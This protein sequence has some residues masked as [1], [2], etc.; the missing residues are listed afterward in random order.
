MKVSCSLVS[1][2]TSPWTVAY[3]APLS[4]GFSRQGYRSG[5]PFP[6]PGDLPNPGIQP[7]SPALQADSL[8]SKPA[9]KPWWCPLPFWPLR[10][11]SAPMWSGR[12]TWLWEWEISSSF[13]SYLFRFLLSSLNCCV[14]PTSPPFF[15]FWETCSSFSTQKLATFPSH[16]G[17]GKIWACATPALPFFL[18]SIFF[19]ILFLLFLFYSFSFCWADRK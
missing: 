16:L 14:S 10:S 5:L 18:K 8:L 9:G 12:S 13:I 4:M 15:L 19:F 7:G 2:S 3:Q 17:A 6:S 11:H 1:D